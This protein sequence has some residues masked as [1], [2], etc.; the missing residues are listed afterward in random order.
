M[1]SK[2]VDRVSTPQHIR[3]R[4]VSGFSEV[5]PIERKQSQIDG[6]RSVESGGS[7]LI[8]VTVKGGV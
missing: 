5:L 8:L 1:H 4:I 7:G 3:G 2:Q 6:K